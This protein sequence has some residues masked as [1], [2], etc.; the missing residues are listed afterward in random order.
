[1][2]KKF[3]IS[4]VLIFVLFLTSCV[5]DDGIRTTTFSE[6]IDEY[7]FNKLYERSDNFEIYTNKKQ[8][9]FYYYVLDDSGDYID[10]GYHIGLRGN[11]QFEKY[12]NL[13]ELEISEG[14]PL[15]RKRYYDVTNGRTSQFF[16]NPVVQQN[17]MIAYFMLDTETN[18]TV[19]IVQNIFDSRAYYKI[20]YRDFSAT[21][22]YG[23]TTATFSAL[24]MIT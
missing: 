18:K 14:G 8:D 2:N 13:L 22:G 4:I 21:S 17:E 12:N 15:I 16:Y 7:E 1:M 19:L 3:C 20:I 11:L 10:S 9:S 24:T 6:N 23:G 5:S